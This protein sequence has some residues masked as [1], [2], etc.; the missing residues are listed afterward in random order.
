MCFILEEPL[1]PKSLKSK[2]PLKQFQVWFEEAKT[3]GIKDPNV[4]CLATCSKY[5]FIWHIK[6]IY[7]KLKIDIIKLWLKCQKSKYNRLYNSF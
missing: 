2:N 7:K 1:S 5:Y 6:Q 3:S 4:V